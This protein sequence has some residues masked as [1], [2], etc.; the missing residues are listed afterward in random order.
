MTVEGAAVRRSVF[1]EPERPDFD[2][3]GFGERLSRFFGRST[4]PVAA[5]WREWLREALS[6][7]PDSAVGDLTSRLRGRDVAHR[8]AVWELACARVLVGLGYRLDWHPSAPTGSCPDWKVTTE[9]GDVFYFEARVLEE[10][11]E[12][13][14]DRILDALNQMPAHGCFFSVRVP[15]VG[16]QSPRTAVLVRA[17]G[18]HLQSGRRD[19]FAWEDQGWR[20]ELAFEA[21]E[22]P[23]HHCVGMFQD[24]MRVSTAAANLRKQVLKKLKKYGDLGAPLVVGV[25]D[26][27]PLGGAEQAL[28]GLVGT[29]TYSFRQ[30]GAMRASRQRDGVLAEHVGKRLSAL[31]YCR[32]VNVFSDESS[33]VRVWLPPI[34]QHVLPT[35]ALPF[36]RTTWSLK[37][38]QVIDLD[39]EVS[40]DAIVR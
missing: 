25:W 37:T 22:G 34:A 4:M 1:D 40:W 9:T 6:V 12:V 32:Q 30:D 29:P 8:S 33:G 28:C 21:A 39:P 24:N 17:V 23:V 19:P 31:L 15:D 2:P 3:R 16:R 14:R 18:A 27:D 38:G 13:E 35:G 11:T 7:V 20:V 10:P 5:R 36:R 26:R